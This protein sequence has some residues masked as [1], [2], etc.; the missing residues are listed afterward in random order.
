MKRYVPILVV[1]A[2]GVVVAAA[3]T[4]DQLVPPHRSGAAPEDPEVTA[5]RGRAAHADDLSW[6]S[7]M[8]GSHPWLRPG[9]SRSEVV[10]RKHG[11]VASGDP[12]RAARE[13]GL[14]AAEAQVRASRVLDRWERRIDLETGL[15]PKGLLAEDNIW[16]YANVGADLYPHLVIAAALLQPERYPSLLQVLAAERAVPQ[17]HS[18]PASVNLTLNRAEDEDLDDRIYGGVEY[19]KDGLLAMAERLGPEPWMERLRELAG[20]VSQVAP[21]KT[22]FGPIPA[23]TAEVNGQFLQVLARLYW[24]T[25]DPAYYAAA[26]RIARAYLELALPKSDWI[27]L[28]SWNFERESSST[29][30][31]QL[32]DHGNEIVAG[33]VE[34]HLIETARWAPNAAEHRHQVRAMLD[35]LLD[36]GRT[37]DGLW[38][39]EID[40]ETGRSGSYPLSDNWGYLYS[41]YLTQALIEETWPGGDPQTAQRYR[42]AARQGL[43]AVS[44]LDLY[45]WQG[46][47]QDGYADTIE[48]ALYLLDHLASPAAAAWVDRQA[49]TLFGMQQENGQVED[50]YLDGNFVRTALLYAAWQ[51]QGVRLD[52]W[53]AGAMVGAVPNGSC[54]TVALGAGSA[55]S[56]RLIF[57]AP[58]HRLNL[59]LPLDYPRLNAW[60]EWFAVESGRLYQ[61]VDSADELSGAH[62]GAALSDGLSL[63]LSAG[64][65]RQL[66]VCPASS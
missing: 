18:L 8:V 61:V 39:S 15:L 6:L 12:A 38:K 4:V 46:T 44:R 16:D 66:N 10:R 43:E 32:R 40:Q 65:E 60:P 29:R 14:L 57:D 5:L 17:A 51:S 63:R 31:A 27:P 25:G 58:R 35:R 50:H 23:D 33:L 20:T 47:E 1:V 53:E 30:Q 59:R 45:P 55:W 64:A 19:A 11:Y 3:V 42:A 21:V 37:S 7:E 52:H 9:T 36:L 56:G 24:A 26:E 49:S 54:L 48:S 22:R 34:F 2:L 28:R 41:A 13:A 62:V